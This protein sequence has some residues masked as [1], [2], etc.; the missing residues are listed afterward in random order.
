MDCREFRT[1]IDS[2]ISD[3]LLVETN[4]E[5]LSHLET[6]EECTNELAERQT[7]LLRIRQ[8]VRGAEEMKMDPAFATRVTAELRAA[9]SQPNFWERFVVNIRALNFRML[10]AGLACALLLT[11]GGLVWIYR[12]D[13]R[14]KKDGPISDLAQAIRVSW[15]QLSAAAIDDHE[16]CA[17]EYNLKEKPISLDEAAKQFGA[18]NKDIDDVI[19][20]A[21]TANGAVNNAN[22]MQFLE[23]HSCVHDGRRF[24]HIVY[25]QNGRLV[26]FLVTDTDLPADND[27][28]QTAI[29][30]G[31]MSAAGF[32]VGRHAVFVVSDL[33]SDDN[34]AIAKTVAPAVRQYFENLGS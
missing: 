12:S 28:A 8:T 23:A 4:H 6:C 1:L 31:V 19:A 13:D 7:L 30:D 32:R 25:R 20:S 16:N 29:I 33:L 21:L 2:F 27:V 22:A 26:S 10:S 34:V 14:S 9:A 24:A 5:V 3:E 11:L 15:Q 18:Y 17:V